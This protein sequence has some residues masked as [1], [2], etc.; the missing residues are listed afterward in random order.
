MELSWLAI[1]ASALCALPYLCLPIL[2]KSSL[3]MASA[4]T[5]EEVDTDSLPH[6]TR[7]FIQDQMRALEKLGFTCRAILSC[8]RATSHVSNYLAILVMPAE[9]ILALGTVII[10]SENGK[11]TAS[12]YYLELISAFLDETSISSMNSSQLNA[13]PVLPGNMVIQ[14]PTVKDPGTLLRLHR[15]ALHKYRCDRIDQPL[16][17]SDW[18]TFLQTQLSNQLARTA[19]N[20][21]LVELDQ[22]SSNYKPTWQGAYLMTWGELWP[23]KP[24]RLMLM[25]SKAKRLQSELLAG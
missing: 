13:F 9:N 14:V 7:N 22:P 11:E 23:V 4:P 19:R 12:T 8:P 21:G 2:I 1:A 20:S 3:T 24:L 15:A 6:E 16:P 18:G 10:A 5:F 17:N 25:Q